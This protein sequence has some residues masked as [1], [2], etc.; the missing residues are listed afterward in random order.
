MDFIKKIITECIRRIQQII[1]KLH[2]FLYMKSVS[3]YRKS[4]LWHIQKALQ[5]DYVIINIMF[6][7]IAAS[8]GWLPF[9]AVTHISQNCKWAFWS[10]IYMSVSICVLL[11]SPLY[12]SIQQ[13]EDQTWSEATM[14]NWQ[15]PRSFILSLKKIVLSESDSYSCHARNK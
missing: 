8:A 6:C 2:M 12:Y 4:V 10:K 3:M 14:G 13:L 1:L 7:C 9:N 15:R 5:L 11:G